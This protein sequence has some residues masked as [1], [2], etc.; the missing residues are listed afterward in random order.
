[1][2]SRTLALAILFA[3]LAAF[4]LHAQ[5]L[6]TTVARLGG[7]TSHIAS[8]DAT[9]VL[10]AT[11]RHLQIYDTT[12]PTAPVFRGQTDVGRDILGIKIVARRALVV[13][14]IQSQPATMDLR[15]FSVTGNTPVYTSTLFEASAL[16]FDS[17]G[18]V[19]YVASNAGFSGATSI[20][21]M[22]V[23]GDF[24]LF[25][26]RLDLP[27]GNLGYTRP[28]ITAT[29]SRLFVTHPTLSG[30]RLHVI[31]SSS[32]SAMSLLGT[33][34]N[35]TRRIYQRTAGSTSHVYAC[36]NDGLD[37]LSL[38]ALPNITVAGSLPNITANDAFI[39]LTTLYVASGTA[40][41]N[42]FNL[43]NPTS[44]PPSWTP[45]TP[46]AQAPTSPSAPTNSSM[47][48]ARAASPS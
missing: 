25:I 44:P 47:P 20:T 8:I 33:H 13:T 2:R 17:L 18:N 7:E 22:D 46:R 38:A 34:N 5:C 19:V 6:P 12:V 45:S 35:N 15:A 29:P 41:I 36:S 48:T 24:P 26:S 32:P 42:A 23:T 4:P 10:V 11:N 9:R 27:A 1:M 40:G 14:D 30:S 43:T 3:S 16:D 37:I 39:A 21:A 28:L 31:N